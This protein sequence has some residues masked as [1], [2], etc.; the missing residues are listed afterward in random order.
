MFIYICNFSNFSFFFF[1][2]NI[3]VTEKRGIIRLL[4]IIISL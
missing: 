4:K 3:P 2:P 1:S